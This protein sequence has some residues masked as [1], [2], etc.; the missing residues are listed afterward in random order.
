MAS[1]RYLLNSKSLL[2]MER[3]FHCQTMRGCWGEGEVAGN[4]LVVILF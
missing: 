2:L 3:E 4:G 1:E